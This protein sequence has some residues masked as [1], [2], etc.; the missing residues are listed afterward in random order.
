M[1][2]ES[3]S[4]PYCGKNI[5]FSEAI[6]REIEAKLDEELHLREG[7]LMKKYQADLATA[8]QKASRLA[9]ATATTELAFEVE[10]LKDQLL[11]TEGKL[12]QARGIEIKLRQER[13]RLEEEKAEVELRVAR[14]IDEKRKEIVE[15]TRKNTAEEQNLILREKDHLLEQMKKQIEDLKR[16]AEQGSQQLQGEVL[17]L[18][19]EERLNSMFPLDNLK[20]VPKGL[21][22]AD[23]IQEVCDRAGEVCGLI[24][25]ETKRTKNWS[26]GWVGKLK[27]DQLAAKADVALLLTQSLPSGCERFQQIDGLWVTS[28]ACAFDLVL[29]LRKGLIELARV[30]RTVRGKNEKMEIVYDYLSSPLFG[31]RVES[32]LNVLV[33]LKSDLEVEK[34]AFS[35]IWAKRQTQIEGVIISMAHIVGDLEAIGD[36]SLAEIKNLDLTLAV[37]GKVETL[38]LQ[39]GEAQIGKHKTPS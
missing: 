27:A 8:V 17:E 18:D 13:Q 15:T 3:I 21:T 37:D 35:K 10:T 32:V 6:S 39:K 31:T 12:T 26:D 20:P 7:N 36:L 2:S 30:R 16:R 33:S 5:P 9:M 22:G 1:I 28:H 25:W 4:C 19:L 24:L 14:E 38:L 11:E 23:L 29:V 34:R